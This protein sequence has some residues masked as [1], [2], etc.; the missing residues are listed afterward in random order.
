MKEL[1]L[2]I[3]DWR[4]QRLLKLEVAPIDGRDDVRSLTV[5]AIEVDGIT[6]T[7]F[8]KPRLTENGV[9]IA[10][11]STLQRN[12]NPDLSVFHI[13]SQIEDDEENVD[14]AVMSPVHRRPRDDESASPN[15]KSEEKSE[16][17]SA[18]NDTSGLVLDL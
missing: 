11:R 1:N 7:V 14:E 3:P 2:E 16:A 9:K 17:E 4:L 15:A 8:K 10:K 12:R 18:D 6:A 13:P 5:S